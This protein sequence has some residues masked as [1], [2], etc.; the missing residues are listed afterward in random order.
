MT[1]ILVKQ[2]STD[3]DIGIGIGIAIAIA[4]GIGIGIGIAIGI[5]IGI[6][7]LVSVYR[8]RSLDRCRYLARRSGT[9][10]VND[11]YQWHL[12]IL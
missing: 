6:G 12:V 11:S 2:C 4:I 7:V 3:T 5:G 1:D 10:R 9:S 8:R